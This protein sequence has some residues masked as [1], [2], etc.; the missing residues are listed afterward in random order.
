MLFQYLCK[1]R[2]CRLD[3]GVNFYII[4]V[5]EFNKNYFNI[6]TLTGD[7]QIQGHAHIYVTFNI[8][9]SIHCRCLILVSFSTI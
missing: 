6:V 4:K 9:K 5:K 2:G 3:L 1:Y 8:S 7:L